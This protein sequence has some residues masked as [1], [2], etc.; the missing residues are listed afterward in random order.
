MR[1][2]EGSRPV[3]V[4]CLGHVSAFL[5]N[6][7]LE[8]ANWAH[9]FELKNMLHTDYWSD[10]AAGAMPTCSTQTVANR[11]PPDSKSQR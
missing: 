6:P 7:M 9:R 10:E 4:L 5:Q 1:M 8:E 11:R 3:A 2:P